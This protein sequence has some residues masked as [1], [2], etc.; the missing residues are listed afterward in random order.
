MVQLFTDSPSTSTVH[1]PHVEVSHPTFVPVS[2]RC[3]LKKYTS[4]VRGST[5]ASRGCPF[6]VTDTLVTD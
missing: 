2:P 5:S 6:T 3:S 1:E 4:S